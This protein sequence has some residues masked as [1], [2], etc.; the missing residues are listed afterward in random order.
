MNHCKLG[1]IPILCCLLCSSRATA[2]TN[3][4][5]VAKDGTGRYT[6]VAEALGAVPRNN[7]KEWVIFIKNGVYKEK[8]RLEPGQ[9]HVVLTGEN[10]YHTILTYDD[11]T[12]KVS[13]RGDTINTRTSA[14]F[15]VKADDFYAENICFQNDAGFTAGQAVG[16]EI[17]GDRAVVYNC[18]ITGNQDILFTSGETSRQYY[19]DCYIEGSTDFIFGAATAWFE[20]CHIHSKKNSHITAASTPKEHAFGYVFYDCVLTG[21]SMLNSV[22]LGRPW[23]PYGSVTYLYCYIDRH[24]RPEGWS[25]WNTTDNYKTARY[26]EYK[27]WGPGA[28]IEK[29]VDWSHQL[30]DEQAAR[31]TPGNVFSGWE[32][33]KTIRR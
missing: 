4:T 24:I 13:P 12:G 14:S 32:P 21:D 19:R 26:A 23:R 3:R 20:R 28:A 17:Q 33:Y 1:L 18:R 2:Q 15:V 27:N 16:L 9:D 10:K 29:R 5:V 22:S 31:Y 30:T 11:H 7:K 8:L 25:N 6:T